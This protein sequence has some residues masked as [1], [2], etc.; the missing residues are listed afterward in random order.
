MSKTTYQ[1]DF[2]YSYGEEVSPEL[3]KKVMD[4]V[5]KM[6]KFKKALEQCLIVLCC[7]NDLS[8]IKRQSKCIDIIEGALKS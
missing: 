2:S 3:A 7:M 8:H 1:H 6:V 4:D 5:Y